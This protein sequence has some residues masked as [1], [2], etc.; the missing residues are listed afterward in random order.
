[1]GS[2]TAVDGAAALIEIARPAAPADFARMDVPAVAGTSFLAVAEVHSS[3]VDIESEP[4][5]I[6]TDGQQSA[7]VLD[8]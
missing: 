5:S 1:M 8:L 6:G 7:V 2:T 3:D 4:S